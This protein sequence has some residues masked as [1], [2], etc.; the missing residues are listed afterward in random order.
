ML[1]I[2]NELSRRD[3]LPSKEEKENITPMHQSL[4]FSMNLSLSTA[5]K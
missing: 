1:S 2:N 4:Q 5:A 3:E